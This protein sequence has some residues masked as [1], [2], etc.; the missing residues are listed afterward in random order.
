MTHCVEIVDCGSEKTPD[1]VRVCEALGW[2]T[3][4]TRLE[5]LNKRKNFENPIIISGGP[6]LFTDPGGDALLALF[7]FVLRCDEPIL[8]ICLGHQG[9]AQMFGG[10]VFRGEEVRIEQTIKVVGDHFLFEGL[11]HPIIVAE[12]H[13]EGVNLPN[14]FI[15]VASSRH[16]A[17]EAMQH[18]SLP[19]FGVQF[20]PEVSGPTGEVIMANFLNFA[21]ANKKSR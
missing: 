15:I 5:D 2:Q 19:I 21:I 16:Y 20:H 9:I 3:I 8:G 18:K 13:C 7:E 17:V 14:E 1:I 6:R 10:E 11:K 12:D 4:V